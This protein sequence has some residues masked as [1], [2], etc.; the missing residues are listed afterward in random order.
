MAQGL[1]FVFFIDCVEQMVLDMD[2]KDAISPTLRVIV[3]QFDENN[4]R[5]SDFQFHGQK[6][7]E[8]FDAA[9]DCEVGAESDEDQENFPSWPYEHDDQTFVAE[10]GSND[11]DPNFSSYPQV[12]YLLVLKC[13]CLS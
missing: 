4:R 10:L 9:I 8:E 1:T 7:A 3:N 12:L 2:I 5:L 11:V 13:P 6:S